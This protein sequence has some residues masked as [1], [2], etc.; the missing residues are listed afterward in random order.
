M[1]HASVRQ[2][3][4]TALEGL[5][6]IEPGAELATLLLQA[7]ERAGAKLEAGDVL[8]IAQKIISKAEGRRTVLR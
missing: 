5:P 3:T 2:L 7:L 4:L 6:E 8:V 1:I